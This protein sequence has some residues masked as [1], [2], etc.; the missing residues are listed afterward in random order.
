MNSADQGVYPM[1]T[2][3][4]RRWDF[5]YYG[6]DDEEDKLSLA[7]I[8]PRFTLGESAELISW[9]GLRKAINDELSTDT[10]NVNEDK[11][12][13]PFFLSE[14][15]LKDN[16]SFKEAFK[17]KVLMYLMMWLN[18]NVDHS[19][20]VKIV[21]VTRLFVVLLIERGLRFSLMALLIQS[22]CKKMNL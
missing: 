21:I 19:L 14:G 3:F 7:A 5:S 10:Y 1:D 20:N 16:T 9:N 4:K 22:G 13:G 11:L 12:M 6:L 17:N 15:A 18:K 2:A 8:K